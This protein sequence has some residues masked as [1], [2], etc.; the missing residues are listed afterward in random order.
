MFILRSLATSV[1][2]LTAA[3]SGW[4][5]QISGEYIEART[6]DVY[7]GPCFANGEVGLAGR[8]ALMA[9]KV[10]KGE[11]NGVSLKGLGAAL[12]LRA[13]D[14]LG[15]NPS[16][17]VN[18]HPIKSM[19]LVDERATAEQKDALVA[20]VKNTAADMA[21]D[22]VKVQSV[23]FELNNDHLTGKGTFKAGDVAAIET[24]GM[25]KG[26]C[27]CTNEA[28]FYPPLTK[29]DN[30]QPAYSLKT[31]FEGKGLNTTFTSLGSRSAFLATFRR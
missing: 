1:L 22:V 3:T 8:E 17:K 4:A 6:C 21:K 14:T 12:V 26:D 19:I 9:W 11:W 27:V 28:V 30:S 29:V 25:R 16:F 20:F 31:S 2:V 10:D 15:T 23:P 13:T 5:A 18:P 7:T 24:R